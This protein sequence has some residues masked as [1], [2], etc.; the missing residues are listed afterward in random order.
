MADIASS[1]IGFFAST[2]LIVIFGEILPQALCSRYALRVGASSMPLVRFFLIIL[3][4]VA[5]PLAKVLDYFLEEDV[6]T[7]HTKNEMM[8]YLKLHAKRGGLDN[9]SGLVMRGALEMKEKRVQSVMTPLEDVYMLPESTRLSFKVVREI[10]E[11]GFS[12]VPVFRGERQ[13]IVGLLFVTVSYT[14]LTLP[15]TD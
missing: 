10:F 6:G 3:A 2:A 15:T 13:R 11:Q 7:V 9:E 12:R 1:L 5:V 4:P 8:H 14:H